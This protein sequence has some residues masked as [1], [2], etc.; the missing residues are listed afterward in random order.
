MTDAQPDQPAGPVVAITGAGRGIGREIALGFADAGT[1]ARL[2]LAARTQPELEQTRELVAARGAEA[3]VVLTDVTDPEQTAA[4]AGAA[5]D[6]FGAIDV[7]VCNSGIAG[8]TA[9]LWEIEPEQWRETMRVNV[10]GVY[11]CCRAVLPSMVARGRGS[12][13]VI[14]SMTGKRPLHGRTPYTTSKLALVGLVRTLAWE[15]GPHGIR[16]NL[17]S[18]GAVRGPR[19]E[20]VIANQSAALA[21][22][23]ADARAR[24][25]S[26]SPLGRLT[27]PGEVAAAAVFLASP[28]AAGITGEDLNVSA[29]V[30]NF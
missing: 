23:E 19:I 15:T 4:M 22:S 18:P 13:I 24:F 14:G 10:D 28:A 5:L 8:P 9:P 21:I 11:L 17:I 6:A 25:T 1:G 3:M 7:L 12:I 2:V 20:A 26:A 29:G 16:V 30:V 27:E